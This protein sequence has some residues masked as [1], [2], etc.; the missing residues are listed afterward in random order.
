MAIKKVLV[1]LG[2]ACVIAPAALA[3][4][5][6]EGNSEGANRVAEAMAYGLGLVGLQGL[7]QEHGDVG[8]RKQ[9]P[10]RGPEISRLPFRSA[11]RPAATLV[12]L[13]SLRLDTDYGI[14]DAWPDGSIAAA[15][16]SDVA[17]ASGGAGGKGTATA[18]GASAG[19]G[20]S[21]SRSAGSISGGMNAG[22]TGSGGTTDLAMAVR[23][24]PDGTATE[25]AGDGSVS[26]MPLPASVWMLLASIAGLVVLGHHRRSRSA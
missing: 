6:R 1:A 22:G 2:V 26:V 9:P 24:E 14:G 5:G 17:P 11:L 7:L 15:L 12:D 19:G 10:Q 3:A 18:H 4:M 16:A 20:A 25:G 23:T 21:F 8:E 13:E